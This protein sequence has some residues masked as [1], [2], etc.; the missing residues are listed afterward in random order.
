MILRSSLG[1]KK[2]LYRNSKEILRIITKNY[3]AAHTGAKF[4]TYYFLRYL[5]SQKVLDLK[6][7]ITI[8]LVVFSSNVF[9]LIIDTFLNF[10]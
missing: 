7:R 3:Y 1:D 2:W 9:F 5:F 6:F 4:L 10:H 8:F